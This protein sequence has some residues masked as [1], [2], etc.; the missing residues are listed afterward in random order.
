M[1]PKA[2]TVAGAADMTV[3]LNSLRGTLDFTDLEKWPPHASPG[4]LGTGSW[5][6]DG[7]LRYKI[8]AHGE[9]F[10]E[11][12]GDDG[13]I[14]GAFFGSNQQAVGGTLR[15]HDLAAG[16]GAERQ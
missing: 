11:T 8:A 6:G 12:G 5:W 10:T 4:M 13:K 14:T 15:R 9:I 7:D 16:F 1:T 2:E 3:Q